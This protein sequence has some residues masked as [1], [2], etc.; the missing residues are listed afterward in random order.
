M[1]RNINLK[2]KKSINKCFHRYVPKNSSFDRPPIHIVG[3]YPKSWN[4]TL[5]GILWYNRLP[6][7]EQQIEIKKFRKIS[8]ANRAVCTHNRDWLMANPPPKKADGHI[9]VPS[10]GSATKRQYDA[11]TNDLIAKSAARSAKAITTRSPEDIINSHPTL[12]HSPKANRNQNTDLSPVSKRRKTM[13]TNDDQLPP[14]CPNCN[15]RHTNKII[16]R[17]QSTIT[18]DDNTPCIQCGQ[19][20]IQ[21]QKREDKNNALKSIYESQKSLPQS[22]ISSQ[23][24]IPVDVL[25][26]LE[27]E[28]GP[29]ITKE[30]LPFLSKTLNLK[31]MHLDAYIKD[32]KKFKSTKDEIDGAEWNVTGKPMHPNTIEL[33]EDD[34]CDAIIIILPE[35]SFMTKKEQN[36]IVLLNPSFDQNDIAAFVEAEKHLIDLGI[37]C[38]RPGPA[39]GVYQFGDE[40]H[41]FSAVTQKD[42]TLYTASGKDGVNMSAIYLNDRGAVKKC[43]FGYSAR[44]GNRLTKGQ[45]LKQASYLP[46]Y[47]NIQVT[48]AMAYIS[49]L[50]CIEAV[51]IPPYMHGNGCY[52]TNLKNIMLGAE[53]NNMTVKE[54]LIKWMST[55]GEQRNHHAVRCHVDKNCSKGFEIYSLFGRCGVEEKED[56][57]LYLPLDNLCIKV[58]CDKQS[59]VCNLNNTPHVADPSRNRSNF[60]KVQGPQP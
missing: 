34:S 35:R 22:P 52:L 38:H 31:V 28:L 57:I 30:L 49:A 24:T 48:E 32:S 8:E 5:H 51:G 12:A 9:S 59:L 13:N 4:K 53:N 36:F 45:K 40:C 47:A 23:R 16:E 3:G 21:Q 60:S 11:L 42:T 29:S 46:A 17:A 6:P 7:E 41:S 55:T 18:F 44:L 25:S 10:Y 20:N 14:P 43:N 26:F 2:C 50:A 33:E 37:T 19:S 56:G 39:H 54:C 27:Q 58:K 1:S 15:F